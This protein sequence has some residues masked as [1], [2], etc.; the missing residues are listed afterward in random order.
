MFQNWNVALENVDTEWFI[1]PSDD[2]MF[3]TDSFD[4][5]DSVLKQNPLG[6]CFYFWT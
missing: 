4:K 2:D 3:C 6:R 1:L 5:I